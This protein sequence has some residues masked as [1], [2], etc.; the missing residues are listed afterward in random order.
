MSTPTPTL[1]QN[2][3]RKTQQT[4]NKRYSWLTRKNLSFLPLCLCMGYWLC[5]YLGMLKKGD[6]FGVKRYF[7]VSW[8]SEESFTVSHVVGLSAANTQGEKK[9]EDKQRTKLCPRVYCTN[10]SIQ[11][12]FSIIAHFSS[13]LQWSSSVW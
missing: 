6:Q 10:T 7:S 2:K 12:S 1:K 9:H 5:W 13:P 3:T 11:A 4:L 8:C